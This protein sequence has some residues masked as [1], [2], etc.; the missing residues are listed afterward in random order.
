MREALLMNDQQRF[1]S[2][3][4]NHKNDGAL[5]PHIV[6]APHINLVA[7]LHRANLEVGLPL[8]VLFLLV[9]PELF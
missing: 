7:H 2:D 5:S 9:F 6:K 8:M 1:F 4:L 3:L